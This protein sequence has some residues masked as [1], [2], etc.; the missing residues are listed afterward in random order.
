LLPGDGPPQE[1]VGTVSI[2][3][4]RFGAPQ[5]APQEPVVESELPPKTPHLASQGNLKGKRAC[6]ESD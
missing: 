5:M 2:V 1:I 3:V 6:E 4:R